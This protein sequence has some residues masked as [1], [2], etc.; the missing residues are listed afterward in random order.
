MAVVDCAYRELGLWV[1]KGVAPL[2]DES[3]ESCRPA[4]VHAEARAE[5]V[6]PEGA[7]PK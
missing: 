3:E 1:S 6:V 5:L 2:E 4:A 7:I